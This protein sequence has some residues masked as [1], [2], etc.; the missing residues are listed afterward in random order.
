M[1]KLILTIAA[2]FVVPLFTLTV[3]GKKKQV[4]KPS[5]AWT[6]LEPLGLHEPST[7]D[8][9]FIDYSR[10]SVPSAV[11]DAWTC[12][13]NLGAE[14]INQIWFDRPVRSDFF[15][16][17]AISHWI[18]S[19]QKE[20]FYNTRIPMTLLSYTTGG[21]KESAQDRLSGTFSGNINRQAQ[22]G[23]LVDYLYS[24]GSYDYQATKNLTWGLNGSYMGDRFEFQGFYYHYNSVNKENGGITNELYITDP[25]KLQ[26]GVSS[27]DAKAIPTNLTNASSRVV[28]GELYL[29][30]RYK[31]GYWHTEPLNDTMDLKTYIPVTSFIWTL[32]Y[33][34][35]RHIFNDPSS[36]ETRNFFDHTYFNDKATYDKTSYYSLSNTFGISMIEGFHKLAKFGLAAYV[37]HEFRKYTQL[38]DTLDRSG[39]SV[40]PLPEFADKIA[41]SVTENMLYVG[42]QLTKQR[43]SLLTYEATARFGL[44]G[45]AVG[46][47]HVNGNVQTRFPLLGDSIAVRANINF[48][49]EHAPLLMNQYRSNH[50]VWYNDFGKTRTL[51]IGGQLKIP[52]TSTMLEAGVENVQ[53]YI[54]FGPDFTPTQHSGSVQII[55]ARLRQNL[56][57]RALHWDNTITWQTT[58]NDAV[59]PLPKLAVYSNL[60]VLFRIATLKVQLGVDCDW[61]SRFYA[62]LYQPV[63]MSFA[64]RRDG[65]VGNYPFMNLYANMKLGKARF[66]LLMSHINQ[67]WFNKNYFSMT[68]YPLNPRRFQLGV[69]VD[70]AN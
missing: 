48:A 27:I 20:K 3:Y 53:N 54:Y 52:Q 19:L 62:P 64:N 11:S 49:N 32:K 70:F 69:S 21:G 46:D 18:P 61:Y 63:T 66:F 43:G 55:S 45:P 67:G 1:R 6:V 17:D 44:L 5:Y 41:P 68:N 50:F 16:R 34:H 7:I 10:Q 60:Y 36:G 2:L 40:D 38:A 9:M 51:R 59:I 37:T 23:A 47:V 58:G 56:A 22:V 31:V 25:A 12:T 14:G 42:G 65:K 57:W 29:N 39:M 4:I 26:G 35:G 28:G 24:K 33:R 30:S 13:G 8:T 15:F